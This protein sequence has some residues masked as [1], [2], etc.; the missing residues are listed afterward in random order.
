MR[1]NNAVSIKERTWRQIKIWKRKT[2]KH[3]PL[4]LVGLL[5]C[6][7]HAIFTEDFGLDLQG[8]ATGFQGNPGSVSWIIDLLVLR[9][10]VQWICH[11][12]SRISFLII[13]SWLLV[14]L[15]QLFV[16]NLRLDAWMLID[17]D[18]KRRSA[19]HTSRSYCT[20]D[21]DPEIWLGNIPL[22]QSSWLALM[23]LPEPVNR[24]WYTAHYAFW[25]RYCGG[26]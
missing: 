22:N 7:P 25:K 2:H 9:Q 14:W 17:L 4:M 13:R 18:Y 1:P 8:F 19:I 6:P 26:C 3:I 10:S 16:R 21:A 20:T 5:K 24:I 15:N 11:Q 23:V 12:A